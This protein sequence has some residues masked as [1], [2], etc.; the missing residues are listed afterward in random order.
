VVRGA[1]DER[2]SGGDRPIAFSGTPKDI[3]SA[4]V[5]R[6]MLRKRLDEAMIVRC[7][8]GRGLPGVLC[9]EVQVCD[10]RI[11][12]HQPHETVEDQHRFGRPTASRFSPVRG[13]ESLTM[14]RRAHG[15]EDLADRELAFEV[16][17]VL[18]Q[19]D[20]V[21]PGKRELRI[22]SDC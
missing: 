22:G 20:L 15:R 14:G 8:L 12:R 2:L 19:G 5:H 11:A 17:H 7:L 16:G 10:V 9:R 6:R 1:L 13:E 21:G 18:V 4:G 3:R